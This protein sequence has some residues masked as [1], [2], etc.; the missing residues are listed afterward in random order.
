MFGRCNKCWWWKQFKSIFPAQSSRGI[1]YY[2]R[3]I[4]RETSYCPDYLNRIKEN[5]K[6][7]LEDW[8]KEVPEINIEDDYV[9]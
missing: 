3:D 5:K 6:Q 9:T 1:C 2:H 7:L 4:T 8:I